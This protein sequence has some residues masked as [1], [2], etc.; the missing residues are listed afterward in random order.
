[1]A[2]RESIRVMG[3]E[4]RERRK[5]HPAWSIALARVTVALCIFAAGLITGSHSVATASAIYIVLILYIADLP[6]HRRPQK[7]IRALTMVFDLAAIS[8]LIAF[9]DG[10]DEILFLLYLFP[11][12]SAARYLGWLWSLLV[13][14]A[15]TAGYVFA[16]SGSVREHVVR[17]AVLIAIAYTATRIARQRGRAELTLL[18]AIE[19]TQGEIL[20]NAERD[21]VLHLLLDTAMGITGSDESAIV[22]VENGAVIDSANSKR[23]S[24]DRS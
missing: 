13:A 22:L 2:V 12:L 11:I 6:R 4:D 3:T 19:R 10:I 15:A 7:R 23:G 24:T 16:A 20:S 8:A 14:G 18:N 17:G 9:T 21:A 5:R 1:M